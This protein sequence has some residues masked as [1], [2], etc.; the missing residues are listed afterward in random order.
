M[1]RYPPRLG[2]LATRSVVTSKLVPTYAKAHQL[3]EEEAA[4]RVSAG[5]AGSLLED[6]LAATWQALLAGT[7]RLDEAGLLEKV[8][9]SLKD[10][11]NRPGREAKLTPGLSAFLV[12]LD[13]AAGTAAES[14]RR[15][16]E[17][18]QGR[19]MGAKGLEEAGKLLAAELTR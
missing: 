6:L 8:A 1:A 12:L 19:A 10:R 2:H 4:Q 3:D 5:L 9:G 16:M 17:S 7:K 18:D 11:P 15:V 13:L 14:A